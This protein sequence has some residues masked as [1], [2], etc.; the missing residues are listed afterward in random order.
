MLT[1]PDLDNQQYKCPCEHPSKVGFIFPELLFFSFLQSWSQYK[2]NPP[3]SQ[4]APSMT[5][6]SHPA[7]GLTASQLSSFDR[8]G[9]LII[10]S[11]L[12]PPT[13]QSL[14]AET[15]SLLTNLDLASHPLTKFSTGGADGSGAHVGDDY[16]L[17]S[18]DKIRF[19]F[20]E[21]AFSPDTGELV[22][23]KEHAI[24][25]IGHYL[26]A[27]SPP[28]ARLLGGDD[29]AEVLVKPAAVAQSCMWPSSCS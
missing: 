4:S 16:F 6:S 5:I 9:Y 12:S 2:Q 21:A 27:L 23:P 28:F 19:F 3:T 17:T 1:L 11:A 26:H 7:G 15:H 22:K 20:E 29:A 25:K 13:I 18:G 8:D 24:N 14:L 10:P